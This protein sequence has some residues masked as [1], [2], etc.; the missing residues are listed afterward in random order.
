LFRRFEA[1][2]R[3]LPSANIASHKI[4]IAQ[5]QRQTT[6][7]SLSLTCVGDPI[8]EI[9]KVAAFVIQRLVASLVVKKASISSRAA[10]VG[11]PAASMRF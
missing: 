10:M 7:L 6:R 8:A 9:S 4:K 11:C 1:S 2:L 5:C 3:Q